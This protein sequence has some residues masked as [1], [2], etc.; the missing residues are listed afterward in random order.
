MR[1]DPLRICVKL[2]FEPFQLLFDE[3]AE[4]SLRLDLFGLPVGCSVLLWHRIQLFGAF[5]AQME[6]LFQKSDHVVTYWLQ[7]RTWRA[8]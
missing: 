2:T 4:L 7:T 8:A 5:D 3:S 1:R 6:T